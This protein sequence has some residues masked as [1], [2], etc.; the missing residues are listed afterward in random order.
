MKAKG[1]IQRDLAKHLKIAESTVTGWF[2]YGR[3]PDVDAL[4]DIPQLLGVSLDWLLTGR[5]D[6]KP[7]E[8][9][10]PAAEYVAGRRDTL[11]EVEVEFGKLLTELGLRW[12]DDE[13]EAKR[14][15]AASLEHEQRQADDARQQPGRRGQA[16]RG[17]S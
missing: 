10:T 3:L 12:T 5:G 8:E 13:M 1:W 7:G 4:F 15:A 2:R 6:G 16:R 17:A 14:R 9:K 11:S